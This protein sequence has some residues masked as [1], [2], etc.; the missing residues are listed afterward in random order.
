[1]IQMSKNVRFRTSD[2]AVSL[3]RYK[4]WAV[5]A[6][7]LVS[8]V[9]LSCYVILKNNDFDFRAALGG[10]PDATVEDIE[11]SNANAEKSERHFLFWCN[12][13]V[14]GDLQFFWITKISMP[15]G[16]YTV[17]SPSL[18]E[19]VYFK[20]SYL[21]FGKIFAL[22]GDEG[23]TK[24]VEEYYKIRIYHRIGS[25]TEQFKQTVNYFGSVTVELPEAIEYRGQFNLILMK[26]TNTLKGDTLYKYLVY[27]NFM[28]S[29]G[30]E[31]R[32]GVLLQILDTVINPDN[33]DRLDK[34]YSRLANTIKTDVTIVGFSA[35]RDYLTQL[36]NTGVKE[37]V[38]AG[39]AS[40]I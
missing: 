40:Q 30:P 2:K 17:L 14:S 19:T 38:I 24:A 29:R 22:Y 18:D 25:D 37:T 31:I 6:L 20:D 15:K 33:V 3:G 16:K 23:L 36:F 4:I 32:S 27:T 39:K 5:I 1:M 35:M 21:T 8:A 7:I 12:D 26:G 34:I 11:V 28:E 10:D 13:S 9:V